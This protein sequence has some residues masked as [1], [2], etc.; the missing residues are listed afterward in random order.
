LIRI[1]DSPNVSFEDGVVTFGARQEW[2]TCA[3]EKWATAESRMD[4]V[5]WM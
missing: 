1:V 2:A 5:F 3:G 4:V